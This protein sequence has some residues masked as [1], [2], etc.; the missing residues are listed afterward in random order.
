MDGEGIQRT[1]GGA[2]S[3]VSYILIV[4]YLPTDHTSREKNK[5]ALRRFEKTADGV[6]KE[7]GNWSFWVLWGETEGKWGQTVW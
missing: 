7:F 4:V 5:R 2:T 6:L 1:N 3:R